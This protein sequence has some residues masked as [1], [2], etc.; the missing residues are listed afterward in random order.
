MLVLEWLFIPY[1]WYRKYEK[2]QLTNEQRP[3]DRFAPTFGGTYSKNQNYK[4]MIHGMGEW[5]DFK[6][7]SRDNNQNFIPAISLKIAKAK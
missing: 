3:E 1:N 6:V 2:D 7:K 5:Q 4:V